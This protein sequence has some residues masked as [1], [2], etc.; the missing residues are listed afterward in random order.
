MHAH[1]LEL[2]IAAELRIDAVWTRTAQVVSFDYFFKISPAFAGIKAPPAGAFRFLKSS[3]SST[4]VTN[5]TPSCFWKCSISLIGGQ[6]SYFSFS[7]LL[8]NLTTSH[9]TYLSCI[10]IAC[11]L[12]DTSGWMVMGNMNSSYSL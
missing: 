12:P 3:A 6:H 8:Y 7:F 9:K 2:S 10:K 4:M 11:G 1:D 5:S